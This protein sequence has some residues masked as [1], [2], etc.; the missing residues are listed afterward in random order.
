[1]NSEK[2]KSKCAPEELKGVKLSELKNRI[3]SYIYFKNLEKIKT[4]SPSKNQDNCTKYL[5]YLES[6]KPVHDR[7]NNAQCG[8]LLFWLSYDT[9]Y[10]RCNPKHK[11]TSLMTELQKC[12]I[13]DK[14]NLKAVAPG[15]D[16]S[17]GVAAAAPAG[18]QKVSGSATEPK[19]SVVVTSSSSSS[20][21]VTTSPAVSTPKAATLST[22]TTTTSTV[23]AAK[24]VTTTSTA[25]A[26]SRVTTTT[27]AKTSAGTTTNTVT[28]SSS[29][30]RRSWIWPSFFSSSSSPRTSAL[31]A[32]QTSTSTS[33]STVSARQVTTTSTSGGR[34]SPVTVTTDTRS[35][36]GSISSTGQGLA[37]PLA[38]GVGNGKSLTSPSQGSPGYGLQAVSSNNLNIGGDSPPA[39]ITDV[40]GTSETLYD[41]L[42]SNTVK[43]IVM[44]AAVLGIIFFLFYYNRSSRI[45]SSIKPKKR[46]NKAFE[47]NY[48]EEYE[49]ELARY[50]SD[51]ESLDSLDDR[52]YLTYQPDQ[53]SHY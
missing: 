47:H 41:K 23:A 44:A 22:P 1:M 7:Y 49:K 35:A 42:D 3:F 45:E 50:E 21:A 30:Q 2:L 28:T 34:G 52:Y 19:A 29:S 9:D 32:S 10:F 53:D 46:K 5:T 17:K 51:N 48:Y 36:A 13:G 18:D 38:T 12:K 6:F 26:S 37:H 25:A 20:T 24:P 4:I 43:N 11:L 15:P 40:P 14:E 33:G 39:T 16:K 27:Q 8:S 31:G